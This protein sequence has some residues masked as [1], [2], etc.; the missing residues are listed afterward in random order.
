MW[1]FYSLIIAADGAM[2]D[3]INSYDSGPVVAAE[4]GGQPVYMGLHFMDSN[5]SAYNPHECPPFLRCFDIDLSTTAVRESDPVETTD[6]VLGKLRYVPVSDSISIGGGTLSDPN[7][8]F[9]LIEQSEPQSFWFREVAGWIGANKQ[10]PQFANNVMVFDEGDEETKI[11]IFENGDEVDLE[12]AA[13][14]NSNDPKVWDL[15]ADL[16]LQFADDELSIFRGQVI[17]FPGFNDLMI[18]ETSASRLID[19]L[20]ARGIYSGCSRTDSFFVECG[21]ELPAI[22]LTIGDLVITIPSGELLLPPNESRGQLATLEDGQTKRLCPTRIQCQGGRD[23]FIGRLLM[24]SVDVMLFDYGRRMIGIVP[25]EGNSTR[26][27][28]PS[29]RP[30]V[31]LFSFPSV[32]ENEAVPIVFRASNRRSGFALVSFLQQ[33]V[34]GYPGVKCWDFVA[35]NERLSLVHASKLDRVIPGDILRLQMQMYA[36]EISFMIIPDSPGS[37]KIEVFISTSP[38]RINVCSRSPRLSRNGVTTPAPVGTDAPCA[39]PSNDP[40]V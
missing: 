8:K 17:V 29:T 10:A 26:T 28:F 15:D 11:V 2:I 27:G 35:V 4:L 12:P 25:Y 39:Q 16:R 13:F 14:F 18:P 34:S 31:P 24:R 5:S 23:V 6:R 19:A 7:F 30:V 33:P 1:K 38:G 32:R 21:S 37:S 9:R 22:T 36:D 40:V 20:A 3:I